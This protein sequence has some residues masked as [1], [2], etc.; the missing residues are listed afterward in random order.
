MDVY[1]L[2]SGSCGN[3]TFV[4][5]GRTRILIDAG[6]SMRAIKRYLAAIDES[7]EDVDALLITHD[8]RDHVR[9]AE[10]LSRRL[11][12]PIHATEKT[13]SGAERI[14]GTVDV[15]RIK[16]FTSGDGFAVGDI[17]IESVQTPH[18]AS[19]PVGYVFE[20]RARRFAM[21]TDFGHVFD[22]LTDRVAT[23][24]ALMLES[25]YDKQML[26]TGSY[27]N[28]LKKRILGPYGHLSN[29]D[30]ADLLF[31]FQSDRLRTVILAHISAE[32]NRPDLA[33]ETV[34]KKINGSRC[35]PD[36]LV[37]ANRGF[38]TPLFAV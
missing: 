9:T 16:P 25:N 23:F 7:L 30:A 5:C 33:M 32:N 28:F 20:S 10:I 8:H 27:P 24:D 19:D 38:P 34:R 22:E 13:L 35:A 17:S 21:F 12:I 14:I 26:E 18:D 4:R 29:E 31:E 2:S 36:A 11:N 6:I 3:S 37:T 15:S 1:V